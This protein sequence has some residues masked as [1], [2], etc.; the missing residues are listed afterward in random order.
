MQGPVRKNI[1]ISDKKGHE[2]KQSIAPATGYVA[3]CLQGNEP[4]E[5]GMKKID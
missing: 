4:G 3:E 5:K 1:I 2:V